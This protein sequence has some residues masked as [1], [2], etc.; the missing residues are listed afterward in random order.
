MKFDNSLRVNVGVVMLGT[1]KPNEVVEVL[2]IGNF[3]LGDGEVAIGVG[4]DILKQVIEEFATTLD[5]EV[6]SVNLIAESFFIVWSQEISEEFGGGN[7]M[8][9][10]QCVKQ[11]LSAGSASLVAVEKYEEFFA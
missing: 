11:V 3:F 9:S 1:P 6:V 4:N 2:I 10:V 5:E 8:T 7:K